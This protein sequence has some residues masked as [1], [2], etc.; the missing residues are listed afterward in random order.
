VTTTVRRQWQLPMHGTVIGS[1]IVVRTCTGL[2]PPLPP[3][4]TERPAPEPGP[5]AP[6]SAPAPA[7]EDLDRQLQAWRAQLTGGL[8]PVALSMAWYDWAAH[9]ADMPGRRRRL[10]EQGTRAGLQLVARAL[11]GPFAPDGDPEPRAG[12]RRFDAPEWQQWPFH[13]VTRAFLTAE[14][15]WQEATT[16]VPGVSEH[17]ERMVSF[18]ARQM[19]DLV[20]PSN[21]AA[22]NP[23]VIAASVTQLGDNLVRGAQ[24]FGDDLQRML[25]DSPPAGAEAFVPG[26]TVAVTPGRVVYRNALIELIQYTPT[27]ETTYAE[28]VLVVPAWIMKYYIL[29]LSPHNSLVKYLVDR[30]HTVFMM[31]WHNPTAE[32]RDLGMEDYL[33]LGVMAALDAVGEIVGDRRINAVGYCLG[34]TMLAIAAAAMARDAD[35]RLASVTLFAAQ[36]DFTEPGEL[37]LF[38][39]ESQ[40]DQLESIMWDKGYLDSP[41]MSGA[42]GMLRSYELIYSRMVNEYLLGERPAPNDLMAWN[43]DGTR[44][45]YRMHSEYLR[46][47]FLR[48]DLFEGRYRVGE[49]AVTLGDIRAPMFVVATVRDHVAPWHSVYKLNLIAETELT[50][51]LCSGGHNAGI[52]SEPGHPHRTFQCTTH[53]AGQ[54]YVEPDRWAQDAPTHEGSWWP[55]WERWLA[56]RSGRRGAPPPQGPSLADA[57]GT[58]VLQR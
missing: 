33:Q 32:D 37:Q 44:L 39:D 53:P 3:A 35:R 38:I 30:G 51:L 15:W 16:D 17:H 27:T 48:N 36:T 6:A 19:L 56:K 57:P 12:D 58:Y 43:A 54:P 23:E 40:I 42:F 47:L 11:A 2:I 28:P 24:L 52:V 10:A 9:L 21:F 34:G 55:T 45:P 8:S 13:L 26:Q 29:D 1:R 20:S 49:R 41:N 46:G 14:Q 22:T 18:M 7:G 31:S 25:S 5:P 50:F 4:M